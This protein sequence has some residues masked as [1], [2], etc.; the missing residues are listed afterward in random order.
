MG[1][2]VSYGIIALLVL[3]VV[4]HMRRVHA[5][6]RGNLSAVLTIAIPNIVAIAA[7]LFPLLS[8]GE[9]LSVI[10]PNVEEYIENNQ[11]LTEE[12]AD[13]KA[14]IAKQEKEKSDL[15]E[16]N[17][18]LNEKNF[19]EIEPLKLVVNGLENE[20][21]ENLIASINGDNY[22][23]ESVLKTLSGEEMI[24]ND[25][26]ST[27]YIGKEADKVEKVPLEEVSNI[28]YSGE[29]YKVFGLDTD[30][31]EGF[32]VAG[33]E[34]NTGFIL[35]TSRYSEKGSFVLINLNDEYSNIE[36]DFGKVDSDS[37]YIEDANLKITS[38]EKVTKQEKI[39]AEV[40]SHHYSFSVQGVKSLK[41]ALYDSGSEFGFYNMV[42]T[43]K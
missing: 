12:N 6:E 28:L 15:S 29:N 3:V 14:L 38:D 39:N 37:R 40:P 1:E 26:D 25:E 33:N 10:Y 4:F 18:S 17:E 35:T 5:Q 2:I 16:K 7:L 32:K 42:L 27:L 30:N 36:F 23:N 8:S 31:I 13:L 20:G 21:T 9:T 11:E 41:I 34:I 43:K 24:Y 22:Y 19:A